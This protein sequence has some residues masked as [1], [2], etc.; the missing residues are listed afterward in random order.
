MKDDD[1]YGTVFDLDSLCIHE[2][3]HIILELEF[4]R[5]PKYMRV[6]KK[7]HDFEEWICNRFAAI[8]KDFGNSGV[9]DAK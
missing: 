5:F 6:H 8:L 4:D 2:M 3:I 7:M 9:I 1:E